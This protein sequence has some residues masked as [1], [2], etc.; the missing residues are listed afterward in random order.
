MNKTLA[1]VVNGYEPFVVADIAKDKGAAL[2]V[3]VNDFKMQAFIA[4]MKFFRPEMQVLELPA[5][6]TLPYDRVSPNVDVVAKRV[7]TLASLTAGV[8]K[9]FVLVTTVAGMMGKLAPKSYFEESSFAINAG[10]DLD[11]GKFIKYLT[12]NGY[13]KVEQV[14]E[15][16][17]FAVRGGI[18]DVF[19]PSAENPLRLDLFGDT[20]ESIRTFDALSQITVGKIESF[21]FHPVSEVSL[22]SASISLFRENYLKAFGSMMAGDE[23]YESISA[24]KRFIGM[25]HWLA[26]F[27]PELATIFDY[28]PDADVVLDFQ[29][30]AA[31]KSRLEQVK[32][33]YDARGEGLKINDVGG[34]KYRPVRPEA[35]FLH[36]KEYEDALGEKNVFNLTPF[37]VPG[38][39][40]MGSR[41]ARDF[42]DVRAAGDKDV[43]AEV[44]DFLKAKMAEGKRAVIAAYSKGSAE[45]LSHLFKERGIYF[46]I[47]NTW[48][49]VVKAPVGK[50]DIVVLALE[51]GFETKDIHM[52]TEQ[53]ILGERLARAPKKQ[54]KN[55]DFIADVSSLVQGDLVVHSEHGI[56]KYE[57]LEIVS[58]DGAPHDCL[59]LTYAGGDKLYVPVENIEV[60]SKYGS[61]E[62]GVNLDSLGSSAWQ[63]RKG[64]LKKRIRD[65]AEKLMKI[66]AARYLKKADI[67]P[68]PRDSYDAFVAGFPYVETD[69]QM[70]S[71]DDVIGDLASGRPMDRLVC[72]DV[73]FGK[74]EVALRASFVAAMDGKQV[75]IVAPTTILAKQHFEL[76]KER[77]KNFPVKVGQ[78]SRM[79]KAKEAALVKAELADGKMDIV[80]GTHALL[81]KT[82]Q[83][84]RL[85]LVVVDEEQHF[86]V[87]HKERLKELADNVHILTLTATPIPRTLQMSLAGVRELSVIATPPVDRL[88]V[89]TFVTPFDNVILR[90]AILR[91]HF[92]GGQ[93]FYVCPRISDIAPVVDNLMRLVPE[94]KISYAHGQM[95]AADLEQK[96]IDFTSRK[97]DVLVATSIIE[98]GID[99]PTVNTIIIHNAH[100]FGLAQLYQ[101]RGR[102][103]RSKTRAYAYLTIPEGESGSGGAISAT[104]LKRLSIMQTLDSLGE[105]FNL[106]SYDLDIRGAGNLLGEEQSGH[107]KEVGIELYQKM[108][109]EAIA[110]LKT[111]DRNN[112]ADK[113]VPEINTG[114]PILIPETYVADLNLR[115][116]LY[117]RLADLETASDIDAFAAEVA[118]RFGPV[119]SELNN[120]LEI[121][122]IKALCH[123]ANIEKIDVGEKG[124]VITLHG[125]VFPNP[126]ALVDFIA[127]SLGTMKVRPDGKIVY[128]RSWKN[129]KDKLK[130][131][132]V[133]VENLCKLVESKEKQP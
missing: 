37:A 64:R 38:G 55:K 19:P 131:V 128:M 97:F 83:F 49:E 85:G 121:V 133:L 114:L 80:I 13:N 69:D 132:R 101:L 21:I 103:G 50:P 102:V 11:L 109:E 61:E 82:L 90:E 91:E 77:F 122:A 130:G 124:A 36:G 39:V 105:G 68:V 14:M 26:F 27:Y 15:Q 35:M 93:V 73:G 79:V 129:P 125:G 51:H 28:V 22:T 120:L 16:G 42:A 60:L 95:S 108:L 65:M 63:M 9:P 25:E 75:A 34:F 32:D 47:K 66:A 111:G 5:W 52:L 59:L 43:F 104:A 56:G 127:G 53:D 46:G 106:A 92:R 74:T 7:V 96:I 20:L 100:M 118:D 33:F 86:G 67:L 117:R 70:R 54:N 87:K 76:F 12:A 88:A 99:M 81:A 119:P 107:I 31:M 44:K 1:E 115:L 94:V 23:L 10:S 30:E 6:D 57:G 40:P 71:I 72:G 98:S 62:A 110:L 41:Q 2:Y 58:V 4:G 45:R 29:A 8:K 84:K 123:K 24:G 89:R 113:W 17:D 78:L 3:A 18:F 116:S 48:A 126:M 112:A